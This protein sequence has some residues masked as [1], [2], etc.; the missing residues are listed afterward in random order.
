MRVH[1]GI[2]SAERA[3]EPSDLKKGYLQGAPATTAFLRNA[4]NF[5]LMAVTVAV[6]FLHADPFEKTAQTLP[7]FFSC[8]G[9]KRHD[10]LAILL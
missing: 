3:R 7:A 2:G 5:C 8:C 4:K 1:G 9:G 10:E 6:F